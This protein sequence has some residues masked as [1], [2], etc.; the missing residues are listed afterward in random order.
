[1]TNVSA[2]QALAAE[3]GPGE[4]T[5]KD[6]V[7]E[8]LLDVLSK[9]RMK[10]QD[11]EAEARSAGLLGDGKQMRQSKP[12]RSAKVE[13][14]ITSTKEVF[15]T[16]GVWYWSL[17]LGAHHNNRAPKEDEGALGEPSA[18][19]RPETPKAP[20]LGEGAYEGEGAHDGAAAGNGKGRAPEHPDDGTI[21]PSSSAGAPIA[22]SW[23]G[24]NGIITASRFGCTSCAKS[25]GLMPTRPVTVTAQRDSCARRQH[26]PNCH[27]RHYDVARIAR[28]KT[29]RGI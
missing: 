28:N 18:L 15:G 9:G 19:R 5:M 25:R 2:D 11:I 13:L 24:P 14:G 10:I 12:F 4:V 22:V 3:K 29:G 16:G 1:M 8:F 6:E 21:S 27:C 7:V 23:A 17:P 20:S 26:D